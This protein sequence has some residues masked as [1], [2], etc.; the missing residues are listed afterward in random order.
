MG[1]IYVIISI[2]TIISFGTIGCKQLIKKHYTDKTIAP[3]DS[4]KGKLKRSYI[5]E[6]LNALA[7]SPDIK[8]LKIGAMCYAAMAERDS[9]EYVCPKCGEKTLYVEQKG[10]YVSRE[11]RQC[12]TNA[13]LITEIELK[14][15]ESQFCKK[16]SPGI[17]KPILCMD[18]KFADDTKSTKVCDISSNDLQII[19]EFLQGKE[20]H[21][22]FNDGEEPMKQ[23]VPRLSELLGVKK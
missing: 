14:L 2:L 13:S 5:K 22:T 21:K 1:Y 8:D 15:D 19:K 20:K 4:I 18:Y 17:E 23:F 3:E 7:E 12:R 9:A 6:K 10:W 16:C 11:L